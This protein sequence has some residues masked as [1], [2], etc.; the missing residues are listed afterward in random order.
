M[1]SPPRR[2]HTPLELDASMRLRA[3]AASHASL[4]KHASPTKSQ[5]LPGFMPKSPS[6]SDTSDAEKSEHPSHLPYDR[7]VAKHGSEEYQQQAMSKI[8]GSHPSLPTLPPIPPT[9]HYYPTPEPSSS[10]GRGGV[11]SEGGIFDE[12][13]EEDSAN[14]NNLCAPGSPTPAGDHPLMAS[15]P[16][17]HDGDD[18]DASFGEASEDEQPALHDE[19]RRAT[20]RYMSSARALPAADVLSSDEEDAE[21]SHELSTYMDS[22]VTKMDFAPIDDAYANPT[23]APADMS[24][25]PFHVRSPLQTVMKMRVPRGGREVTLGRSSKSCDFAVS[26][27]NRLVSRVHVRVMYIEAASR[28]KFTC[29]GWNG[30]TIVV[31]T[32]RAVRRQVREGATTKTVKE[33]VSDGVTDY[34]VPKDLGIEIKYVDGITIDVRGERALVELV[35]DD[36]TQQPQKKQ[37]SVETKP[38]QA[39]QQQAV[40]PAPTAQADST[41]RERR[42]SKHN[43]LSS[44]SHINVSLASPAPQ[45][46][47]PLVPPTASV[48]RP[49]SSFFSALHKNNGAS[50]QPCTPVIR[51][52]VA[53]SPVLSHSPASL[54]R[55]L[56]RPA[57]P[58]FSRP[59]SRPT[60][61]LYQ[62]PATPTHS[63]GLSGTPG[64]S[65]LKRKSDVL[66]PKFVG[67][68]IVAQQQQGQQQHTSPTK[69][70][71]SMPSLLSS[72]LVRSTSMVVRG[73][74]VADDA[75]QPLKKRLSMVSRTGRPVARKSDPKAQPQPAVDLVATPQSVSPSPA[76]PAVV[77]QTQ[78]PEPT[79]E[80]GA[81]ESPRAQRTP[82]P[83]FDPA[84]AET[85][86]IKSVI[87]TH[88]ALSRLHSSPISLI[89]KSIP[90]LEHVHISNIRKILTTT[91]WIGIIDREG[92]DAAGKPL[93]EEYYYLQ[94][95]DVDADRKALVDQIKG[96]GA[97][98]LRA[99]RKTHKQYYWKKPKK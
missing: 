70:R 89:H 29:T 79:P 91:P 59:V 11:H 77:E 23:Y 93:E 73:S 27:S 90:S 18:D 33:M 37:V 65:A 22:G 44:A 57:P 48:R 85:A 35:D 74:T 56:S 26:S 8:S 66:D 43:E 38:D 97:T 47:L 2:P 80:D 96:R 25:K 60:S 46:T 20:L 6:G 94:D 62:S 14:S 68:Y 87:S 4:S 5:L 34:L 67:D 81:A 30:C 88:L 17:Y 7:T 45:Q 39:A 31:P 15:S 86:H 98:G 49:T 41:L 64:S 12:D 10:T 42:A 28:I 99:C 13:E 1:D 71:A 54:S 69:P 40:V 84:S 75:S 36:E 78:E 19:S 61:G 92:K 52:A 21:V 83:E 9:R 82:S 63:S 58:N 3:T 53:A 51:T 95:K 32:F 24:S 76:V 16:Q 55:S 50:S 72:P